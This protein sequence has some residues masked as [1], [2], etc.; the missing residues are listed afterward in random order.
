M[1]SNAIYGEL[2]QR[3]KQISRFSFPDFYH[4]LY[5]LF[6]NW[7]QWFLFLCVQESP[8]S[9]LH[10]LIKCLSNVIRSLNF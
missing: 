10:G 2:D 5:G 3:Q 7:A 9:D 8:F 6:V 1:Y 4:T